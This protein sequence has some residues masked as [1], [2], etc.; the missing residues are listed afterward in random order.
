[1][2]I[3]SDDLIKWVRRSIGDVTSQGPFALFVLFHVVH[4]GAPSVAGNKIQTWPLDANEPDELAQEIWTEA[5]REAN[6]LSAGSRQRFVILGYRL[7]PQGEVAQ[8][9]DTQFS[10]S[11]YG[12]GKANAF[13]QDTEPAT[14]MGVRAQ[15]MRQNEN[16]HRLLIGYSEST[17]GRAIQ[18]A[19]RERAL[20]LKAED[21]LF[22]VQQLRE[23]LL[24]RKADR[25]LRQATELMKVKQLGDIMQAVMALLPLV[26]A[27]LAGGN[28][29]G[30][31]ARDMAIGKILK[32][33]DEKQLVGVM[34]SLPGE[35]R[36]PLLEIY[37]SYRDEEQKTQ[38]GKP[39]LLR[40]KPAGQPP[41]EVKH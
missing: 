3:A 20:R 24:D 14:E 1:M 11:I 28:M 16:L 8:E 9:H 32:S 15:S 25:E 27:K 4:D 6:Q 18:D 21:K 39:D 12:R 26:I 2:S 5:E 37:K 31:T 30:S 17:T 19:E 34:Q 29:A 7:D 40:D 36:L 23:E 22:E 13:D 10:F 35:M 38:E 41:A 33:L